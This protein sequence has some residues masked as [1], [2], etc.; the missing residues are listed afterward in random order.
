VARTHPV[1]LIAGYIQRKRRDQFIRLG[2]MVIGWLV[3]AVLGTNLWDQNQLWQGERQRLEA[4]QARAPELG[5]ERDRL[6]LRNRT[7]V[8]ERAL[9][10]GLESAVLP[11]VP[12]R[13]LAHLAGVLPADASLSEFAVRWNEENAVW[14]FQ[15]EGQ[16]AGDEES[17]REAVEALKRQLARGPLRIRFAENPAASGRAS[18]GGGFSGTGQQRFTLEGSFGEN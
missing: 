7:L 16:I 5:A 18:F 9:R 10:Q 17:A 11:P 2:L 3:L 6:V 8:R 4:L 15:C 14:M 12:A 13:L 1:N